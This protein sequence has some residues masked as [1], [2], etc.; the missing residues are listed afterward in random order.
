MRGGAAPGAAGSEARGLSALG[1]LAL[2]ETGLRRPAE[3]GLE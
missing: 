2:S 3:D 1:G